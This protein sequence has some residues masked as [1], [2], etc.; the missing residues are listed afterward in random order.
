MRGS[1]P[2]GSSALG[3]PMRELL[4]PVKI[5]ALQSSKIMINQMPAYDMRSAPGSLDT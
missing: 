3:R 1:L 2:N 5:I 4:P